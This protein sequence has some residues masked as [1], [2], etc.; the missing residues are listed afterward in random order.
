MLIGTY[1]SFR[2]ERHRNRL[3]PT[4]TGVK[5]AKFEIYIKNHPK[6]SFT[7]FLW[8]LSRKLR[9]RETLRKSNFCRG[10]ASH[11]VHL[12]VI[13]KMK[14]PRMIRG[15]GKGEGRVGRRGEKSRWPEPPR[16][17]SN[18]AHKRRSPCVHKNR[19]TLICENRVF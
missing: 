4:K 1:R 6:D 10:Q 2:S 17:V 3:I 15:R 12:L 16:Q 18:R 5:S 7:V 19:Q 13:D 14:Y 11:D 9:R 8:H